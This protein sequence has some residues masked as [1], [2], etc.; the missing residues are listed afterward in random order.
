MGNWVTS[1]TSVTLLIREKRRELILFWEMF[2][3]AL[4]MAQDETFD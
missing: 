2:E 3:K 1:V 4:K